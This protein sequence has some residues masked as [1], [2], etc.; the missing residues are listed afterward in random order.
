MAKTM[1]VALFLALCLARGA[2]AGEGGIDPQT[3]K[4]VKDF[5]GRQMKA[6]D[7][8][9][10]KAL[11]GVLAPY[12]SVVMFGNGPD[13]HWV[14][15]DAIKKADESQMSKHESETAALENTSIGARG[16]IAWFAA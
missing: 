4:Q 16:T 11:M 2:F 5:L 15:P 1:L 13:D 10:L 12:A 9:D 6:F 3:E 14:W 7:H 8:R